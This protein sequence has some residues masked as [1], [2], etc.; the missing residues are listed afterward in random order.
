MNAMA[1]RLPCHRGPKNNNHVS[2]P[3]PR[4]FSKR[5][6]KYSIVTAAQPRQT[7]SVAIDQDGTDFS[8]FSRVNFGASGKII[9]ML[10]DTGAASTWIMGSNCTSEPCASHNTFG[11]QDSSTLRLTDSKF[12][13]TYG[14]GTVSG[15]VSNDSISM[16]GFSVPFSFGLATTVSEDFLTYPMDGILGLGRPALKIME[17]PTIMETIENKNL[18]PANIIGIH[19]Q[20]NSD[21]FTDGEINFGSLD[22]TRYSGNLSYT[23]TTPDN[24]LWE[25][26]VDDVIVGGITCNFSSKTGIIDTGTSFILLPPA[27]AQ[28]FHVLIPQSQQVGEVYN[29]PCA[30]TVTVQIK[31]SGVLYSITS[32]DYVGN[33]INGGRL[34]SSNIIGRQTFGPD[35]WLLGDV[36]LKN[37]YT[38]F[39]FDKNRIGGSS[40]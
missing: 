25:I 36:F 17:S 33:S 14:T 18:L 20:R 24:A 19:L 8:Y 21:G 30:S 4:P 27:D 12:N 39:D 29:I 34:C 1:R 10:V 5:E 3:K 9:Y 11:P 28:R 7:D 38:V 15:S 32:K 26:P 22:N 40:F 35:K 37:V 23:A 13:L 2:D 16:A 6:N 31:I